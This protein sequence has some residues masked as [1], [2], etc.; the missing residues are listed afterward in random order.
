MKSVLHSTKTLALIVAS[1]VLAGCASGPST[2][3]AQMYYV[4]AKVMQQRPTPERCEYVRQGGD[5]SA[6]TVIGLVAGGLLGRQFG[7][8]KSARNWATAVG[9]IAGAS[10]G[11][12]VDERNRDPRNTPKLE[13]KQDGYLVTVGYIHPV[14]RVYQVVTLP[15][16][17]M[18]N[19]EFISVP[20]R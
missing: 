7:G 16:D 8:S 6:G 17:R 14:T 2:P 5:S 9:A 4:D 18:T 13:C 19:A 20:V 3:R 1:A 11:A 12:N 10:V 15:M